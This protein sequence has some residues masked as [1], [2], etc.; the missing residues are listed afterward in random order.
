MTTKKK[1]FTTLDITLMS[2]FSALWVALNLTVAPLSFSLTGLPII[3]SLIIYLILLLTAWVIGKFGA[4]I[5]VGMLG[6]IIVLLAGGPPPVLGFAASSIIVDIILLANRHRL[7]T[8]SYSNLAVSVIATS[9]SA[10]VA[11]I[12]N[13]LFIIHFPLQ[14]IATI[15]GAWNIEG[16][17]A[18]LIVALLLIKLLEKSNLRTPQHKTL[19][20]IN[21]QENNQNQFNRIKIFFSKIRVC[22]FCGRITNHSANGKV[23]LVCGLVHDPQLTL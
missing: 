13:G 8:N 18:G 6:T 14:F 1:Y 11:A 7:Q 23:C 20:H 2:I 17:I 4:A 22:E 5:F 21:F 12:I 15:W 3:H 10:Y 9:I 16:A 19:E